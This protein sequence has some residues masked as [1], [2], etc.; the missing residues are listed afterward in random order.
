M[1]KVLYIFGLLTDSDVEWIA[2]VG[3][4]RRLRDGEVVIQEGERPDHLV[5]LLQGEL[6]ASTRRL[7]P[8]ARMGVGEVVGEMSL[9]DSAPASA[10]ITAGGNGLALFLDKTSLIAKLES[11]EGFGCRF[12]RALAV[13][14]A[15][16]LRDARRGSTDLTMDEKAISDD[17]LDGGILDRV[18]AAG[19]R[20]SRMLRILSQGKVR[21]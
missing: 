5:F 2:D 7:G 10:T 12:Y 21:A 15:D 11:D 17:E 6:L 8:I 13:F 18:A 9:V 16:R 4:Q 14:L 1:R 20:F 19:E 3:I